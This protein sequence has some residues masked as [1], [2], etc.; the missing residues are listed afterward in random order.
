MLFTIALATASVTS[1][2]V[3]GPQQAMAKS[4]NSVMKSL[5]ANTT[6]IGVLSMPITC[7]SLGDI[8][9][10]VSGVLANATATGGGNETNSTQGMGGL[11]K[12]LS[13]VLGNTTDAGGGG[14]ETSSMQGM[15]ASGMQNM[16]QSKL[17]HLNNLEFCSLANEKTIK[18]LMK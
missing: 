13:G 1:L 7:N 5:I 15:M 8:M 18:S 6:R 10:A 3:E 4:S 14:N 9:G 17:Q 11:M 12:E 16:S 2:T